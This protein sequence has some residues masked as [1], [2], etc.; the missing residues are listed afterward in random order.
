MKKASFQGHNVI[1][2]VMSLLIIVGLG[3]ALDYQFYLSPSG[4]KIS[5][6]VLPWDPS[7]SFLTAFS[8]AAVNS[9]AVGLVAILFATLLGV[10]IGVMGTMADPTASMICRIYV[11]A[12]RNVP[13]LFV[14]LLCYFVGILMPA[15]ARAP[16]LMGLVF[17]SNRGIVLPELHLAGAGQLAIAGGLVLAAGLM[18]WRLPVPALTRVGGALVAL[19][20]AF[21][22]GLDARAPELGKFGF[23]SG[24]EVP[25]EFLA[26]TTA[27]SFYFA[28]EIAEITRGAIL[29]VNKGVIEAADALG[30]HRLDRFRKITAPLALRFGLPGA[31]NSYLV[32]MKATSLGV[33]IGYTEL[34]SVARVSMATSGR[35]V[36][37]LILMGLYFLLICGTLSLVVNRM[38]ARLRT[39][40]R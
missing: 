29:S 24:V 23:R 17:L 9:L 4:L 32:I 38:N 16:D 19:L 25:L 3:S 21:W 11:G 28:A 40:E 14:I 6:A 33:A 22:F 18:L 39:R 36:E 20:L 12:F 27:L 34:F 31:L 8:V 1:I 30:L 7:W 10:G 15:P 37:C 13:V 2:A 35:I 5:S 26:L